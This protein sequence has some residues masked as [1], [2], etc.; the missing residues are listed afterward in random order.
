[1]YQADFAPDVRPI[2]AIR[3]RVWLAAGDLDAANRWARDRSMSADA[4]LSYVNEYDHITFARVLLARHHEHRDRIAL[5]QSLP[6]LERLG[7]AALAGNR[8]GRLIEILAVQ[9]IALDRAGSRAA[10]LSTLQRCVTLAEREGHVRLFVDLGA[11]M[12]NLL[13]PLA[14]QDHDTPFLRRLL[15]AVSTVGRVRRESQPLV[16]P[17]SER[18]L[19]VLRL[20]RT[21][22]DGP[23][24][25]RELVVSLNTVRTHTKNIYAKLGVNNR[26]AAVRRADELGLS[27]RGPRR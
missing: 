12:A 19:D 11:P 21:D 3:A 27:A 9:A 15:S 26:R 1:V 2:P 23:A 5:A 8:Q 14:K 18:E 6:L 16:E 24:I 13:R 25:A 4:D 7:E 10:G 22:L 20:L 17:L